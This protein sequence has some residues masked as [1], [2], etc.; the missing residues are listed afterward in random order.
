MSNHHANVKTIP[1]L[2]PL[3]AITISW[4]LNKYVYSLPIPI[5]FDIQQW[6]AYF[7]IMISMLLFASSLYY[8][9]KTKQNPEPHTPTNSLYT[10]GIYKITRNPIYLAFLFA[11][12]VVAVKLNNSYVLLTLPIVFWLLNIW[13][14]KPEEEYL[15]KLFGQQY[16]DY[17]NKVRRWI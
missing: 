8:F 2:V 4:A 6:I 17:K 13:V 9:I 3:M 15:E 10:T 12:I 14:I 5:A 1:P 16:L 7:F 11:Q